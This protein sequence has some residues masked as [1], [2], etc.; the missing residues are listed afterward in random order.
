[1]SDTY[2]LYDLYKKQQEIIDDLKY[3]LLILDKNFDE[4]K[5]CYNDEKI[6]LGS[7]FKKINNELNEIKLKNEMKINN[8]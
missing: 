5:F 7:Q 2:I 3:K 4:F 1:M 6:N 8:N